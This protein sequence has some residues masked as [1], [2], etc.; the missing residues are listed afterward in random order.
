LGLLSKWDTE[1]AKFVDPKLQ[2][3]NALDE[4]KDERVAPVVLEFLEDVNE[5]ARFHA[6]AA[7]VTQADES[8]IEPL[9]T[10]F[11]LEESARVQKRIAEGF[12][13]LGWKVPA[14]RIASVRK[15]LPHEWRLSEDGTFSQ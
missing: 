15:T 14:E 1:Y 10:A 3:L 7:L 5:T 12:V 8:T 9:L 4:V 2:L 11:E 6:A 13:K